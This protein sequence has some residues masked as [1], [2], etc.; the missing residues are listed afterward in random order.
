MPSLWHENFPYVIL[1][2]F[3]H[4]KP[5][6]GTKRGGIPEMVEH[7]SRGLTYEASSSRELAEQIV[8]LFSDVELIR[9]MGKNGRLYVEAE[10]NDDKFYGSLIEIYEEAVG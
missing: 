2:S 8:R 7:G 9:E 5:V 10:F 6:I 1:Q 3:A 4:A